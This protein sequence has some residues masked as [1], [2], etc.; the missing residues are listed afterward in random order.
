MLINLIVFYATGYNKYQVY[1]EMTT[2]HAEV[3]A[4]RNLK[5]TR[6]RKKISI[7]VYRTNN[8]CDLTMA[9]PCNNCIYNML[10]YAKKKNYYIEKIC[11]TDWNGNVFTI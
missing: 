2:I 3:D 11:Y 7:L 4:I 10:K 6:I 1:D 8:N 5:K 9:K